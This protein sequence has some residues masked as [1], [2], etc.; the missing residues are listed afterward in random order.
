MNCS[1]L[2]PEFIIPDF[3]DEYSQK[4]K[5]IVDNIDKSRKTIVIS[6]ATTWENKHW[7]IQGWV[8]VINEFKD[9]YNIV[10]TA[11]E[12]E[13]NLTSQILSEIK[14][15]NITDLSGET[16]LA[17][18]VYI[19]KNS[20]IVVSPDSGSAHIAWAVNHPYIITLFFATSANRTAPFGDKY[21][22][23]SAKCTCS[24]CMKKHC[25]LKSN[26]N[27]CIQEIKSQDVINVIK[28]VLQ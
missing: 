25:R 9:E 27:K 4:I 11:S 17:D 13:K 28:K 8:D 24:P 14:N 15:G 6:P 18:M 10:I 20:D 26:K 7:T 19:F 12:K 3:S 22:S 2:E 5:N 16:T 21:F 23:L 1:D